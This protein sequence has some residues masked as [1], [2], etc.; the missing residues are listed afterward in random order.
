M[1]KSDLLAALALPNASVHDKPASKSQIARCS[2]HR[3]YKERILTEIAS[4]R[5]LGTILMSPEVPGHYTDERHYSEISFNLVQVTSYL[6]TA[7]QGICLNGS[8]SPV[9]LRSSLACR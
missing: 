9:N 8:P 6:V 2:S 1:N 4:V 5:W 3:S 7:Q